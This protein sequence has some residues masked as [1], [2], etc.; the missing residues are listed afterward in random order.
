MLPFALPIFEPEPLP[1]FV[2]EPLP[3]ELPALLAVA[4]RSC[5]GSGRRAVAAA[6]SAASRAAN[7]DECLQSEKPQASARTDGCAFG[8]TA[9]LAG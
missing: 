4:A 3:G 6:A 1:E 9:G 2:P 7:S 8:D 5:A